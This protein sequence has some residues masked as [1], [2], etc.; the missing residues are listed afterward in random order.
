MSSAIACFCFTQSLI[1]NIRTMDICSLMFSF[2]YFFFLFRL[3]SQVRWGNWLKNV[4]LHSHA[5]LVPWNFPVP[6]TALRENEVGK[7]IYYIAYIYWCHPLEVSTLTP[8][9]ATVR[10]VG[11]RGIGSWVKGSFT[12]HH[13][14]PVVL[15]LHCFYLP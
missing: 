14:V 1:Y 3:Y 6:G 5:C 13:L 2:L 4:N 7:G 12:C 15:N 11:E 9:L 8:V 10:K